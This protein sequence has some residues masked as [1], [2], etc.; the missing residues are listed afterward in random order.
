MDYAFSKEIF[1]I[2]RAMFFYCVTGE[3]DPDFLAIRDLLVE[4]YQKHVSPPSPIT[5]S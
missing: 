2:F 1:A 5:K 3:Q 4:H